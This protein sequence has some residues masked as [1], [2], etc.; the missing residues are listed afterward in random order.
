[1]FLNT[2]VPPCAA[3]SVCQQRLRAQKMLQLSSSTQLPFQPKPRTKVPQAQQEN[4]LSHPKGYKCLQGEHQQSMQ[5][6]EL[7]KQKGKK[8]ITAG[9][10]QEKHQE[11]Q[12][13]HGKLLGREMGDEHLLLKVCG[14]QNQA[15]VVPLRDG[16][17]EG[18]PAII[19]FLLQ[20]ELQRCQSSVKQAASRWQTLNKTF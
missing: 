13:S 1:M 10:C 6:L 14:W 18:S 7:L 3:G 5:G 16:R 11:L 12:L 20:G 8:I 9:R 2:P 15:G 4:R 17:Q 19:T